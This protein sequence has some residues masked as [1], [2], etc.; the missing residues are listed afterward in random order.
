[1]ICY[2]VT[3][4]A[5]GK[6]Y[7]GITTGSMAPRWRQ[8]CRTSKSGS[9]TALHNAI[10]KHGEGAFHI[11]KIGKAPSQEE[12]TELETREI[13]IRRTKAPFGYNLTS[14]GEG[15]PG[16]VPGEEFRAKLS[17]AHKG[18]PKSENHR[19]AMKKPKT[20]EHRAK[21]SAAN[22]GH[23][24]TLEA[25]LKM[26]AAAKMRAISPEQRAKISESGRGKIRSPETR[27]KMAAWQ[28][29]RTLSDETKARISAS[30][31]ALF[32]AKAAA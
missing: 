9:K 4:K 15:T 17:E 26:S 25:R 2:L 30:R 28:V 21:I 18:K 22:M 3:N 23:A 11:E 31:K 8:H 10:R 12:L 14:G 13:D 6:Q 24:I 5:N 32:S 1:V 29:G 20:A 7:V 16:W 19:A 27:A